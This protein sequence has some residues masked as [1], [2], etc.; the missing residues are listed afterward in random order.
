MVYFLPFKYKITGLILVF[1]AALLTSLY[2]LFEIRIEMP[3]LALV[4][5]YFET[6]FFTSFKTNVVEELIIILFLT[7]FSF[8]VF[9]KEKNEKPWVQNIRIKS[10]IYTI[11]VYLIWLI[12]TTFFVYG[13]A[14]VTVL[15]VNIVLP[16]IIYLL[17][18]YYDYYKTFK[19]RRIRILQQKLF[20]RTA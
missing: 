6:S 20:R 2:F 17:I 16:F 15:I 1:I 18:F 10:M 7:G 5:S 3:V 12:I 8:M 11:V 4:S 14:Y 19:R 9:S 13:S